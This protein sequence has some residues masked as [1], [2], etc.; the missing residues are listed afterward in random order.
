MLEANNVLPDASEVIQ[1]GGTLDV[2]NA[3]DMAAALK[4]IV[5]RTLALGTGQLTFGSRV[6]KVRSWHADLD[7]Y[8]G[9]E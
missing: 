9:C 2:G 3:I 7:S 8:L 6:D 5:C 4:M 1:Y